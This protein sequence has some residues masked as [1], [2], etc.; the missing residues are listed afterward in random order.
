[1]NN[2]TKKEMAAL[3]GVLILL[4]LSVFSQL[5]RQNAAP[6]SIGRERTAINRNAGSNE[7]VAVDL[8]LNETPEFTSVKRNIFQFGSGDRDRTV[9]PENDAPS[10][11]PR[12]ILPAASQ[13]PDVHY[14]GFYYEKDTGLKMASLSNTGRI[15]V[16]KVG[17]VLGGKYEVMEIAQDYVILKLPL[18]G[19]K[20]IRVPFGRGPASTVES[21]EVQQ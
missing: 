6:V 11:P 8:L 9:P 12:Q 4:A 15:Y 1:M 13:L 10:Q 17:Q 20:M 18:E 16:G 2:K 14:L 7:V 3:I 21:N 19:G 5:S